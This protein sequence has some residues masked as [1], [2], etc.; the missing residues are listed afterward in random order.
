MTSSTS[1]QPLQLVRMKDLTTMVGFS[2]AHIN[3]LIGE[4]R[5]PQRLKI[6]ERAS[7]WL[8]PEIEHWAQGRWRL[9]TSY[10]PP[11]HEGVYLISRTVVLSMLGIQK[12]TLLRLIAKD[13]FPPGC[14]VGR[15]EKRWHYNE[16]LGWVAK[17]I[18]ERDK[19]EEA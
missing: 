7:A 1:F 5:F 18:I 12:D 2:C 3:L 13:A 17:K 6:G 8:L 15:R 11:S 4:G 16:V 19:R 14:Q 9:D 10:S